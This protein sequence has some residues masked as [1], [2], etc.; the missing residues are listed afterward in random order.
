MSPVA[1]ATSRRS[2]LAARHMPYC[3]GFGPMK[4]KVLDQ[5]TVMVEG[6]YVR[7]SHTLLL[8]SRPEAVAAAQHYT[9]TVRSLS[10]AVSELPAESP[11]LSRRQHA[12]ARMLSES[13]S[14][15]EIARA[16][17]VSVRTVRSEVASFSEALGAGTRFAAGVRCGILLCTNRSFREASA[18]SLPEPAR[19]TGMQLP[20]S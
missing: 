8:L 9:S 7:G 15:A 20:I 16:L 5:R 1:P 14:D 12:M 19:R 6:P 4:F 10:V 11:A 17:G 18:G 13:R 3:V 2:I